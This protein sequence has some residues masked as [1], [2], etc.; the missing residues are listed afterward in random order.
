MKKIY[1][2]GFS[3]DEII[4]FKTK[5]QENST[6][7]IDILRKTMKNIVDRNQLTDFSRNLKLVLSIF[8]FVVLNSDI[9]VLPMPIVEQKLD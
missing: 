6:E 8:L 4:S 2:E 3:V 1:S 5:G 7:A 9:D